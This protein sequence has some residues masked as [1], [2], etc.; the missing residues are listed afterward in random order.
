LP[1]PFLVVRG[2]LMLCCVALLLVELLT[3]E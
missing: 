1:R 3:A 2:L